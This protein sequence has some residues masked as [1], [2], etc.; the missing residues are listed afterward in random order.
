MFLECI[1]ESINAFISELFQL[2]KK[3]AFL[4]EKKV[5]PLTI[6]KK[7]VTEK[8]YKMIVPLIATALPLSS[9]ERKEILGH[10]LSCPGP[11]QI[12]VSFYFSHH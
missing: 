3:N 7:I 8:W 11:V 9:S 6:K 10:L 1:N 2:N 4:T 12:C 5:F